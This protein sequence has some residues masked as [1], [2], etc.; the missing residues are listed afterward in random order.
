M[1]T[2]STFLKRCAH[3]AHSKCPSDNTRDE[4]K[5]V[6]GKMAIP[7]LSFPAHDFERT[8]LCEIP[9]AA[10]RN[11]SRGHNRK[12]RSWS[13]QRIIVPTLVGLKLCV[14]TLMSDWECATCTVRRT[15]R[16]DRAS[17]QPPLCISIIC[18]L[19]PMNAFLLPTKELPALCT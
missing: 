8:C 12:L 18:L 19:T 7:S 9:R 4:S 14:R 16:V 11:I 15:T 1:A 17:K 13:E 3:K 2:L 10:H 6:S 5:Q